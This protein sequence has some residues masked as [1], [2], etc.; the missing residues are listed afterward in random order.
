MTQPSNRTT[1]FALITLGLLMAV[2]SILGPLVLGLVRFHTSGPAIT[3]LVGGDVV[4]LLI[5]APTAILA[6]ILWLRDSPLAPPLA[7]GPAVYA[8]YTYVQYIIG[9]EYAR[10]P[11]NSEYFIPLYILLVILSW[12]T[13]VSA[14]RRL[15]STALPRIE[16][17]LQRALGALMLLV[18]LIFALA[19]LAS[20]AAVLTGR[21]PPEY[22]M[23]QT[24]FWV[25]RL[26]D[27]G[28]VIPASFIVA[29]GLLCRTRRATRLAYGF[30]G[31]QTL[32]VAA[33]AGMAVMMTVRD[34]PSASAVLIA[35]SSLMA[36]A[37][38]GMFLALLRR[39]APAP[40]AA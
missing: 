4:T 26:M 5:V 29:V 38:T 15:T 37:L 19:W 28:F 8:L 1:A 11:G 10:Y 33:G 27:L 21:H 3:Q 6:G 13:G 34:D 14:W 30:L 7:L 22:E 39:L 35:A 18:N 40:S 32:I 2:S 24:L 20:I 25:V 31:F 9:P 17:G 36:V 16:P 12:T 23:D